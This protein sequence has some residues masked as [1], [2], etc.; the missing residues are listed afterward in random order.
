MSNS[1]AAKKEYA[2][3]LSLNPYDSDT[4]VRA[5]SLYFQDKQIEEAAKLARR[6]IAVDPK[7]AEARKLYAQ[8]LLEQ[9]RAVDA[10]PELQTALTLDEGDRNLHFLMAKAL[11]DTGDS[12]RADEEMQTFQRLTREWNAAERERRGRLENA[13]KKLGVA[14]EGP[15]RP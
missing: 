6:A 13:L 3:E 14:R 5:S 4:L 9:N 10:L 15:P 7:L 8:C 12:R 1:E 11:R 2:A